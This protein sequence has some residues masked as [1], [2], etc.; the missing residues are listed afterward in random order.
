MKDYKEK[1]ILKLLAVI[2]AAIGMIVACVLLAVKYKDALC[3]FFGKLKE[4]CPC[5]KL[6]CEADDYADEELNSI[7][8]SDCNE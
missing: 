7:C 1:D 3:D 5:A 4:K 8:Y 6:H 2:V